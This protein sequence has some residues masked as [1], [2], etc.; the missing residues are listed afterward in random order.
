MRFERRN[1]G[2][3]HSYWLD[4]AKLPGVTTITKV[5]K[6]GFENFATKATAAAAVDR[7]DELQDM[8]PMA[9]HE[10]LMRAY[11]EALQAAARNGTMMH[12]Y[13]WAV[14][15]GEDVDVPPEFVGSVEA[16]A[17]FMDA[18]G[19]EPV[20]RETP[21]FHPGHRWAG[22]IDLLCT[23]RGT[24]WLLDWK[25]GK[26]VW[27]ADVLQLAAYAHAT[28]VQT[29]AGT[30]AQWD[31]PERC[32]LVHV[33]SDAVTLYPVDAGDYA[34]TT[35]RYCQQVYAWQEACDAAFKDGRAWPIGP[36]LDP[37]GVAA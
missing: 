1:H 22:T 4:G 6:P 35:F 13:S 24:R 30:V 8:T 14:V 3:W 26:G 34:Y 15:T 16:V 31:P 17:R 11:P 10:L 2:R 7:W 19:V 32:G 29:E 37:A 20:H 9:R 21:V 25:T 28:H 27:P 5:A 23:I 18:W 12:E 33:R 36:A